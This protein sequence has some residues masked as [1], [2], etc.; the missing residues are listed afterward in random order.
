[1]NRIALAARAETARVLVAA[2]L[3]F[4]ASLAA[5]AQTPPPGAAAS[6]LK[7]I[8]EPVN[9]GEDIALLDVFFVTPEIGY[10]SGAAGTILKTADA[11]ASWTALL[12][13]DPESQERAIKQLWFVT[14]TIGWAAQTTSSETNLLRTTDGDL[15][16]RIGTLPEHYEDFA[17]ASE[18]EGVFVNDE[19]IFRT[20]DAGKT[21]TEV[22]RCAARA[23][24]GGLVRQIR[25]NLWKVRFASPAV[26][27]A[28]GETFG[29]VSA[30]A[31]MKSTD[32]GASWSVVQLLE[33][34]NGS[35][36]GL[37][38]IDENVGY[39]S[40]KDAKS[41][42]R[43]TDGGVT[44]TGMPATSIGRRIVFADPGVGWAMRYNNLSYTTDGGKRWVSRQLTFPAMPNAFSLPRRDRAYVVGDH[45]MIYR[46]SVV[47]DATP[48]AAKVVAAPA[49]PALDNAVL[50]QIQQLD[51]RLDKID[52]VVE[53]A[54]G[55]G[56]DAS[57]GDWSN[58]GVDQQLAQ[59]QSTV[60]TVATGVPAMGSKHRNLNLVMFGLQLLGDLT[61]QG[62]GLKEAFTSLR[63][64][65]DLGSASTALQN[66]HSTLDSMK[67]SVES[68]QTVRRPGG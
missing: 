4:V 30:A 37:F 60:D 2:M 50:T 41:A 48:V 42:F 22:G 10:V 28:F 23:E 33:N 6:K 9:Y 44:W 1:M 8:W 16:T 15:W 52:A 31:V 63:Q 34:E 57:A 65:P 38:F 58:A 35:E 3:T 39:L 11:G 61:G 36:S 19:Q 66:L 24:V 62:N 32:G 45:G 56:G 43:T 12:G 40:T 14:P 18:A 53:A 26:V 64:S 54:G 7:G 67:T 13:G 47:P 55:A 5:L 27:Y 49:M 25:C 59:L 21:W 20:Q 17:F 46:Y 29:D 51:T 68:F